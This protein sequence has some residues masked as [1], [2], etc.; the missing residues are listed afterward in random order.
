MAAASSPL[1]SPSAA[2]GV[3]HPLYRRWRDVW[4]RSLDVFE[5]AGGFLDPARPYL[6]P[7]PREWLDHSIPV[8][9]DDGATLLRYDLNPSP[10]KPSPKLVERRTLARYEN[11]AATLIEQL[12]GALFREGPTRLFARDSID[13]SAPIQ[14]FWA[15][16]DGQGTAWDDA[17][18]QAWKPCAAFGHL[19]GY[20]DVRED[21]PRR[22]VVRWYTPID[23]P[24]WLT[25]VDGNLVAVRFLEAAPRDTFDKQ[26]S[27]A[28]LDVRVREVTA[29]GWTLADTK[30]AVLEQGE[31]AF[32]VLPVFVLFAKRRS[33]TPF[34]GRSV[35]GDPQLY[36]D[37]YNLISETRELLRKQTFSITN[38][39]VGDTVGGV[40]AAQQMIGAQSGTGNLLFTPGPAQILSAD[41]GNVQVYH[42]HM[43]RLIRL[44]YRI[45]VVAWESDSR[46]AESADSRRI[47]REDLNQQLAAYAD[48]CRRVDQ[49]VTDL[50]YR[51]AYGD[52][53]ETWRKRDGLTIAWPQKF[54]VTP[55]TDLVQQFAEA[56]GLELGETATQQIKKRAA[57]AILPDVGPEAAHQIDQEI[58]AMPVVTE[59]QRRQDQLEAMTARFAGAP[60]A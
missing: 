16:S 56:I 28:H 53:W 30:G 12:A 59:E 11:I 44:I 13:E 32:G 51:A 37:L 52:A 17:L 14:Q 15:D 47:K 24:D 58:E 45:S 33:L 48:E 42:E 23:V 41:A 50:V 5:G 2:L 18:A 22:A 57:R 25:D 19:W 35:L 7:H 46:D 40:Q 39:P 20:V 21:D 9:A 34:V 10:T 6:V 1:G 29:E 54:D 27:V 8:Y 36:I 38:V 60:N 3:T 49:V 31:H 55:L 26:A 43:D 4:V